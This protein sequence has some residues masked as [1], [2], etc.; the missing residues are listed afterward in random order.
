MSD[1]TTFAGRVRFA[2]KLRGLSCLAL[3]TK[4]ELGKSHV[5]QIETG[6]RPN[7]TLE[8]A[9]AIARALDVDPAWLMTGTGVAPVA[10]PATATGTDGN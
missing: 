9:A 1:L 7:P 8:T 10:D 5:R 6:E 2:R 4:A 3:S